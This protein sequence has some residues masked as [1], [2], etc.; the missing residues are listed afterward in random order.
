MSERKVLNKYY[1]HDF[2]PAKIPK[3]KRA[4]KGNDQ[5]RVR[6]MLPMS[7]RCL[8][9]GN[10]IYKGTKFNSRKETVR[11]ESYLG[12]PIYRFYIRCSRCASEFTIK[13]DP[14][15]SDYICENGATSNFDG[16]KE[17]RKLIEQEKRKKEMEEEENAMKRLENKS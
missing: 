6:M 1:P 17:Q 7:V 13:T 15:N 8:S 2:D 16:M 14:E 12:I 5:K 11:G 9:C 4:K 3:V 10:F